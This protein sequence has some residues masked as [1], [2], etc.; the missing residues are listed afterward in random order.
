[1]EKELTVT[2][3]KE[4][5]TVLNNLLDLLT[6]YEGLRIAETTLYLSK[7]IKSFLETKTS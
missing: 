1:M 5:L 4:E 2:F 3:T 6:K 7:K